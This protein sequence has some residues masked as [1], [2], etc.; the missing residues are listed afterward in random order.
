MGSPALE[1]WCPFQHNLENCIVCLF[2]GDEKGCGLGSNLSAVLKEIPL[3]PSELFKPKGTQW[4]LFTTRN[5]DVWFYY[6][7][8]ASIRGRMGPSAV[9]RWPVILSRLLSCVLLLLH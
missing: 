6:Q 9:L 3:L 5:T 4:A 8:R 1:N 2:P 7:L